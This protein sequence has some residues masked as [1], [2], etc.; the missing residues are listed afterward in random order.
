MPP[1]QVI[2]HIL[3][4]AAATM[5]NDLLFVS[6]PMSYNNVLYVITHKD[7]TGI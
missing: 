4:L 2:L 5:I 6:E 7:S 1:D 3:K